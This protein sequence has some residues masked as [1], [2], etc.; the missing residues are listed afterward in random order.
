M[1]FDLGL[2][3]NPLVTTP[4]RKDYGIGA[5]GAGFIM[6]DVHLKAYEQAGFHV[7]AIT[8]RTPEIAQEVADLRGIPRVYEAIEDMLEDESIQILDIAVPPHKQLE[9]IRTACKRGKHL[10]GILAQKPLAVNLE[11]A[12]ETVRLCE[13]HH[14]LLGVNQN[15]R[16]D[17]S[18]RV[19]EMLLQRKL[20]GEPVL[21]TIEMRAVPHWQKWLR[22]YGRL[23]LLNMS[24]HHIDSFRYLFGEP[25]SIYASVRKDPR[26]H[27][28]HQDG[29][30]IYILEY[31][32]GFRA[33]A[34][35]DVY[36]GPRNIRDELKPYIKWRVEGTE[37]IA[38]GTLGWPQYPN[39]SPST[40]TFVTSSQPGVWITPRWSEVWFPDAFAGPMADLMNAIAR[41]QQPECS[42]RDNLHT[43]AIIEAA[44]RSIRERRPVD[45]S[46]AEHE[47]Q[48]EP[49]AVAKQN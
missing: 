48:N 44:Y 37:G 38:E 13:E 22:D 26:T 40:L 27:F 18:I 46:E 1:S 10:K 21:A 11:Q 39:R 42:G 33:T 45:I 16:Y 36:A 24:I 34:W 35:D 31:E 3:L 43:M 20:L 19:L 32:N 5:V 29:I 6:R 2:D 17:R 12:A 23:T 47:A 30:C 8:S 15:M 9:I 4:P 7:A 41:G 49:N 14:I 25:A 28:E